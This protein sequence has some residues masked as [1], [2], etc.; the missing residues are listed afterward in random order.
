MLK[1][2]QQ[3]KFEKVLLPI[4]DVAI[5]PADRPLVAFEPFFTHVL[6]HELM[7]GLGPQA[8]KVGGRDTTVRQEL[9]EL[10][11]PLEEAK[12]DVSGL[13]A[14]QYL[15]DKGVL[16]KKLE[17][18]MY[19]TFLAST[20]RTLR[21]GLTQTHAKGIAMQVNNLFDHG[22]IQ[23]AAD[24]RFAIDVPKAKKAVTDLTRRI[25]TIQATGDYAAADALLK[26]MVTIRPEVQHVIDR[27]GDVPVDIAPKPVTAMELI[28]ATERAAK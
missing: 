11:G 19:T 14:L 22:A 8:I 7:H 28:R 10:N 27:L 4:S 21:F 23:V 17:K 5:V 13:W 24:G 25:M 18:S 12:A 20:F 16:D 9:K 3:A 26:K 15:M 1:N 2:F 6:M